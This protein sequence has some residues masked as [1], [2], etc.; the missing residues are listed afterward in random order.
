M[1]KIFLLILCFSLITLTAC[2]KKARPKPPEDLA[3]L[4]VANLVAT[5]TVD[6]VQLRWTLA[7]EEEPTEKGVTGFEVRRVLYQNSEEVSSTVISKTVSYAE[8][9]VAF[10]Y[11][12]EEV[13]PGKVYRY[14]VLVVDSEGRTSPET[15]SLSVRF[16]GENSIVEYIQQ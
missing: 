8:G 11:L 12:D 10:S 16:I 1:K 9:E 15:G 13:L 4:P 5:G 2:G 6:G 3:P 7:T 14:R